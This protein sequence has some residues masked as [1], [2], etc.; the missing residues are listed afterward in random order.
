[1]PLDKGHRVGAPRVS[2]QAGDTGLVVGQ[3]ERRSARSLVGQS[4]VLLKAGHPTRS[5]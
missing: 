3:Q 4:Q 1:M 5:C 2:G